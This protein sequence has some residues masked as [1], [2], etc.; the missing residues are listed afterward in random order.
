MVL[1]IGIVCGILNI[2]K[3]QTRI[4]GTRYYDV[5]IRT[6]CGC[7]SGSFG[8]VSSM[9][10]VGNYDRTTNHTNNFGIG[11]VTHKILEGKL[12]SNEHFMSGVVFLT[13]RVK[14]VFLDLVNP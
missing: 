14:C 10:K 3:S 6:E 4:L 1:G 7:L 9:N 8:A 12:A 5:S 2:I 13:H 11:F